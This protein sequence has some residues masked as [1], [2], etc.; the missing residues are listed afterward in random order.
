MNLKQLFFLCAGSIAFNAFGQAPISLSSTHFPSNN[1]T[2][3][4]STVQ[5]TA[6]INYT[7]TGTNFNWNF[8]NLVPVSQGLRSYKLGLLTPYAIF[9]TGLTEYGEKIADTLGAGPLTIT[10]Y[11]NFYKKQTTPVNAYVVDGSGMTFSS[12]PVP[13]YYS[14]KDELYHFPM[15]YPKYDS[16]TFKFSTASTTLIPIKYSKTGYR[17]TKVDGWGTITTPYGTA[18]CLHIVTTQYSQDSIKNTILPIPIGFANN[19]RSYQWLTTTSKIPYLEVNGNLVGNNFTITQIRFRDIYRNITSVFE[20]GNMGSDVSIYPNPVKDELKLSI[21]PELI[22]QIEINDMNGKN[23]FFSKKTEFGHVQNT[24]N[25][26][27]LPQ[28]LYHLKISS[29]KGPINFKFIKQ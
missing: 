7:Q 6:A 2:L 12:I 15:T 4:Y 18:P 25:V 5:P 23:V 24:L 19:Q 11:Y 14:D 20:Q 28:G 1:D 27:D 29:E 10:N 13:S 21:E 8:S 22:S 17:V 3:R 9:F 16:T 26:S